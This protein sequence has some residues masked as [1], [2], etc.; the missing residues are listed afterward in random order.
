MGKGQQVS[1][2]GE[3]SSHDLE[4]VGLNL[5]RVCDRFPELIISIPSDTSHLHLAKPVS[6]AN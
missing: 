3:V 2:A 1:S 6:F 5:E 4:F